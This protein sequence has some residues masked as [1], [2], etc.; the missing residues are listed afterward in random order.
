[1][2]VRVR[3]GSTTVR[4]EC[5]S[6][7]LLS[8]LAAL[9]AAQL[10]EIEAP[11]VLSL[12][13]KDALGGCPGDSL[14]ACGVRG[15]DLLHVLMPPPTLAQSAPPPVHAGAAPLPV[16]ASESKMLDT[17]LEMG[18]APAACAQALQ[19]CSGN[20]EEAAGLLTDGAFNVPSSAAAEPSGLEIMVNAS[21][22][23]AERRAA[24]ASKPLDDAAPVF[25]AAARAELLN[26]MLEAGFQ[27]KLAEEGDT[28]G[29]CVRFALPSS[30]HLPATAC[31]V[32]RYSASNVQASAWNGG[33]VHTM[34]LA[35]S[36]RAHYPG[37]A[38][39]S[40]KK[41]ALVDWLCP[42]ITEFKTKLIAP[43]LLELSLARLLLDAAAGPGDTRDCVGKQ[44]TIALGL[45]AVMLRSGFTPQQI[46][47]TDDV[48]TLP[49]G[50]N[51]GGGN[52]SF[53]YTY[54]GVEKSVRQVLLK[55][56]AMADRFLVHAMVAA[57]E[58]TDDVDANSSGDDAEEEEGGSPVFDMTFSIRSLTQKPAVLVPF[59]VQAS[60]EP[61]SPV[62]LSHGC[63]K[64][65]PSIGLGPRFHSGI[66]A[67]LVAAIRWVGHCQLSSATLSLARAGS[68]GPR[69]SLAGSRSHSMTYQRRFAV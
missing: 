6:A 26:L 13:R 61:L 33:T 64:D 37:A 68:K 31:A 40:G 27:E 15:G 48:L 57:E 2:K 19:A 9:A 38:G 12:N 51:I 7:T 44:E 25:E 29:Y 39:D 34:E 1:M 24:A 18:F 3:N 49:A 52:F 4:V 69:W 63:L 62:C 42:L 46:E 22:E 47:N 59:Q 67:Q 36:Q 17:L 43:M 55:C 21:L 23:A 50:W 8:E 66:V 11:I 30:F 41:L 54:P 35:P 56:V 32:I 28:D 45:H 65:P 53:E 5:E 16:P 20:V 60:G 10:G 58:T 14:G